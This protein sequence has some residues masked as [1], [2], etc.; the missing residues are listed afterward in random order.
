MARYNRW[1]FEHHLD[2]ASAEVV[3]P[4]VALWKLL[5]FPSNRW[6]WRLR[7]LR[8]LRL[9]RLLAPL[10]PLAS[11]LA[12]AR[13]PLAVARQPLLAQLGRWLAAC[14]RLVFSSDCIG[15]CSCRC[16]VRLFGSQIYIVDN[17]NAG[18]ELP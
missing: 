4:L 15:N 14:L 16:A 7:W 3:P 10:A 2:P 11:L 17:S 12:L 6:L 1:A 18:D 9:L 8:R 5:V 13:Q